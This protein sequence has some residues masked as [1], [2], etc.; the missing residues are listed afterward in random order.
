M[1]KISLALA[2]TALLGSTAKHR[3]MSQF[4]TDHTKYS[5]FTEFTGYL[6]CLWLHSWSLEHCT[7][8]HFLSFGTEPDF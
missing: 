2:S 4:L 8:K 7:G 6:F 1:K 5:V 3:G